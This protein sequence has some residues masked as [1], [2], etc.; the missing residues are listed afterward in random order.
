MATAHPEGL[1]ERSQGAIW[2][3]A[4][5]TTLLWIV[6]V[7][8]FT[9]TSYLDTRSSGGDMLQIVQIYA[10]GFLPWLIATP[11]TVW[12]GID[13]ARRRPGWVRI[14][15][16]TILLAAGI[17]F[18]VLANM[19]V[20]V[21]AYWGVTAGDMLA[22]NS[23]REWIWDILIF[24]VALLSGHVLGVIRGQVPHAPQDEEAGKIVVRS[25]HRVDIVDIDDVIAA[26]AQGNYVALVTENGE[27]LHRAT[28]AEMNAL[29]ARHGFV[30]VHRSHLVR[31][32]AIVSVRRG[33]GR[34]QTVLMPGGRE[35]PVSASGKRVLEQLLEVQHAA[36]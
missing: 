2:A 4:R 31:A 9:L 14:A 3:I 21:A 33:S 19:A 28:F 25:A 32:D 26:T 6:T 5:V 36:A 17:T 22:A 20:I 30:Q 23:F 34:A 1:S 12:V 11:L 16:E 13:Q 8:L 35:F 24:A 7:G 27:F 29:L 15:V 18:I 10:L